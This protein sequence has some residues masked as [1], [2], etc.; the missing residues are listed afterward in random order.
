MGEA[1][2]VMPNGKI[3]IAFL[4]DDCRRGGGTE[5][6][7]HNLISNI[8]EDRFSWHVFNLRPCPVDH[9]EV[10]SQVTWLGVE[11]LLSL[12]ALKAGWHMFRYLRKR[13]V[14]ILQA[15]FY[16]SRVFG[17][18][19]GRLARVPRIIVCRRDI[20]WWHTPFKLMALRA[21]AKIADRCLV[22]SMAVKE[23]VVYSE[24]IPSEKVVVV[25]NGVDDPFLRSKGRDI[26]KEFNI[27]PNSLVVGMIANF[28]PVKRGDLFLEAAARVRDQR[29]RFLMVGS[30]PLEPALKEKARELNL[31]GRVNFFHTIDDIPAVLEAMEIGVLT[32]ESE[33]LSNVLIEYGFAGLPALAFDTGGNKE[34][35]RDGKTGFVVPL[36]DLEDMVDK[37]NTLVGDKNLRN[38]M[39]AEAR[40]FVEEAFSISSMCRA[41]E[42][43]YF[44]TLRGW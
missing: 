36:H 13:K 43:F 23:M 15:F 35:I 21:T 3:E 6:Q 42:K 17:V 27:S 30:G 19:L 2:T 40:S 24:Q 20:G 39:G 8:D 26:R 14:K 1:G 38:E 25:Y 32:S 29:V 31:E 7:L 5:N 9:C 16:D 28:R 37:L 18:I 44:E 41:T 11:R 10:D 34:V 4:I 33:G 12:A 22:N